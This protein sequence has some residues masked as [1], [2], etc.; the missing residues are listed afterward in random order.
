[1]SSVGGWKVEARRSR[2]MAVGGLQYED[3]DTMLG[4]R[5][6]R[7]RPTGPAPTT[8]TSSP[9]VTSASMP[10]VLSN[11]EANMRI[12]LAVARYYDSVNYPHKSR[13]RTA[14][15]WLAALPIDGHIAAHYDV[16][17]G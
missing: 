10:V 15:H 2:S 3:A 17:R 4:Q 12:D 1:M 8:M 9:S 14:F 5:V 6:A 16:L 11:R 7:Q 13:L